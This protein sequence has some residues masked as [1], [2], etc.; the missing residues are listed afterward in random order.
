VPPARAPKVQIEGDKVSVCKAD[1]SACKAF[2]PQ[3]KP[4]P[5]IGI[6]AKANEANTLAALSYYADKT[7]VETFDPT[8]GKRIA[9]FS[10]GSKKIK[11]ANVDVLRDSILVTES[12]CG[13]PGGKSW[14][15]TKTGK[16]IADVAGVAHAPVGGSTFAFVTTAGDKVVFQD[17]TTGKITKEISLGAA[18]DAPA[19]M[20]TDFRRLVVVW[21]GKRAGDVAS[22]DLS[23]D[24]VATFPGTRCP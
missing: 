2:T 22:I 6:D 21:G 23:N 13:S 11:C 10:V 19:T 12:E 5:G 7:Y 1:G 3:A 15:A 20:L 18:S 4:D 14:L 9:R 24:K 8:T 17:V 16:K